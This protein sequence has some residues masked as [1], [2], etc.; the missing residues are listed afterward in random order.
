MLMDKSNF[1]EVKEETM[2][3]KVTCPNCYSHSIKKKTGKKSKTPGISRLENPEDKNIIYECLSC[4]KVFD[5]DD[6]LNMEMD[7]Y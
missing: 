4:G 5:E 3:E 2:E 1:D 7:K 6:L